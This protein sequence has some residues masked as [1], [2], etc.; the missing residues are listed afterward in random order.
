M[1]DSCGWRNTLLWITEDVTIPAASKLKVGSG[2]NI[3]GGAHLPPRTTNMC[4]HSRLV[5]LIHPDPFGVQFRNR[6]GRVN[7]ED[8]I[9]VAEVHVDSYLTLIDVVDSHAVCALP[10][11]SRNHVTR[12]HH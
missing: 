1:M 10:V 2:A 3:Y 7:R 8:V 9:L 12:S 11:D 5:S 4:A 6:P